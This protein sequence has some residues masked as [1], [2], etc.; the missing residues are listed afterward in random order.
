VFGAIAGALTAVAR[1]LAKAGVI[2][3]SVG[4]ALGYEKPAPARPLP[5][6]PQGWQPAPPWTA[7]APWS[8][9]TTAPAPFGHSLAPTGGAGLAGAAAGAGVAGVPA[10]VW[11]GLL[12][13]AALALILAW[14]R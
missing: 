10:W 9:T 1:P 4:K 6:E 11:G 13:L 14:R 12:A 5:F 7:P 8:P 3:G 2:R